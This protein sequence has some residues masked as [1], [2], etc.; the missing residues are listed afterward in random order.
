MRV[1][2]CLRLHSKISCDPAMNGRLFGQVGT[3]GPQFDLQPDANRFQSLITRRGT[4]PVLYSIGTISNRS[5][6]SQ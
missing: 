5:N 1:A 4:V 6:K 2:L 3:P